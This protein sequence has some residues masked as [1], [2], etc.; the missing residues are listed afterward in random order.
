MQELSNIAEQILTLRLIEIW[1]SVII[2]TV[3]CSL[4]YFK[5]DEFK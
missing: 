2:T 4:I 5:S 3:V 1:L